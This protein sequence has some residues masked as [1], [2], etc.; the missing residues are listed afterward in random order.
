VLLACHLNHSSY[1]GRPLLQERSKVSE[2]RESKVVVDNTDLSL[3]RFKH[4][5]LTDRT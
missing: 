4:S 2:V 5:T 1:P 3:P